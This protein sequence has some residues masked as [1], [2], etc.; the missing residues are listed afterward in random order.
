MNNERRIQVVAGWLKTE[1]V[2]GVLFASTQTE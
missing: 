2:I 1:P